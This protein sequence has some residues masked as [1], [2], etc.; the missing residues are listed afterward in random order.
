M[1]RG[2]ND[3]FPFSVTDLLQRTALLSPRLPEYMVSS[4]TRI[5]ATVVPSCRRRDEGREGGGREK[6]KEREMR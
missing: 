4:R 6:E 3:S 5:A 2:T 1:V